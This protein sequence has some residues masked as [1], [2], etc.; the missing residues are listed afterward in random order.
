METLIDTSS[1][2]RINEL[3][4]YVYCPRI[5]FYTMC[6]GIDRET[7]LS[8]SGIE[9]ESE[10]KSLMKRRKYALH[11]VVEGVRHFDVPALSHNYQ[12]IGRIDELVET[13][14]GV[15]LID[16]KDTTKDF[17]YWRL[18][19]AAYRLCIEEQRSS[20]DVLGCYVYTIPSKKYHEV[21]QK[22]TDGQALTQILDH[23]RQMTTYEI[24]PPPVAQ[25][26]KCRVC[27]YA[28]FCN[29]VF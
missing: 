16:Y 22:A 9:A 28:R 13:K 24:C 26:G 5:S 29:D 19:M 11:A 14:D 10:V 6:L 21:N 17:G 18:Q 7:G 23:L 2:F 12:L 20:Q 25:I 3:K 27:Q 8:R 4:N 1:Y 15:Y